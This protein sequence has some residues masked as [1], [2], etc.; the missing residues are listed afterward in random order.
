MFIYL[1]IIIYL[2]I[3][4]KQ[5]YDELDAEIVFYTFGSYISKVGSKV[6]SKV[7]LLLEASF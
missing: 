2:V 7:V 4:I 3:L 1:I 5:E 6:L